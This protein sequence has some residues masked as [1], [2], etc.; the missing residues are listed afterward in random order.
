LEEVVERTGMS[1]KMIERA[2]G[3]GLFPKGVEG[4]WMSSEVEGLMRS[5]GTSEELAF[6]ED[7]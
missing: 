5:L 6:E 7:E 1:S 2:I 3:H 4:R